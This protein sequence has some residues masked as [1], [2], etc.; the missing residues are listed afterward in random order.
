[1]KLSEQLGL[2]NSSNNINIIF[3]N[4]LDH[5]IRFPLPK[6]Q[7]ALLYDSLE[8]LN[9]IW[10]HLSF[11]N[12]TIKNYLNISDTDKREETDKIS[13]NEVIELDGDSESEP[14]QLT[15]QNLL[16]PNS[17]NISNNPWN[18]GLVGFDSN[19]ECSILQ[20]NEWKDHY[21][22]LINEKHKP[23]RIIQ[24]RGIS[25]QFSEPQSVN[26]ISQEKIDS[27]FNKESQFIANVGKNITNWGTD[28]SINNPKLNLENHLI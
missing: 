9:S 8:S 3:Q 15:I 11:V 28:L 22:R 21:L 23:D 26:Q 13:N 12:K 7:S 5:W 17:N 4:L 20:N 24:S 14:L 25:T 18:I 27:N 16:D 10:L 6:L 2:S 19:K 1:M